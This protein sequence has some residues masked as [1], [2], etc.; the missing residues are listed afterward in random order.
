MYFDFGKNLRDLRCSRGLTQEQAAELL[1][2]SKQSV[3]R[4]ENNVTYPDITFL[5][6]LASFYGVTVDALLG[7]DRALLDSALE[8]YRT[9]HREAH[10][11]GDTAGALALS[12]AM[13]A[14]LPNEPEVM[15]DLMVDAYLRAMNQEG[16]GRR[17][18]LELSLSVGE[19]FLCMTEDL[20]E[21][22]RCIRYLALG[23]KALGRPE[24]AREQM[25]KLPSL[26]SGIELCALEVLEG[27][28]R[29]QHIQSTLLDLAD[30]LQK[31]IFE[32]ASE[33]ALTTKERV[34]ILEK[35]P[36]LLE[37]LFEEGDY[38]LL[39]APLS[40][41]CAVLAAQTRDRPEESREYARRALDYADAA[42]RLT[43]GVHTSVLFRGLAWSPMDRTKP[44]RGTQRET[45]E[46]LLAE[47]KAED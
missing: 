28:E 12:Q 23:H 19:R 14:R 43:P 36:R 22:C 18:G 34:R 17:R 47:G 27:K 13:Y 29:Q 44:R 31:L 41:A 3:S 20:E 46:A 35:L 9:R 42:D 16:E 11:R 45:V 5:P 21:K 25:E 24:R 15:S 10:H 7:A 26:W 37:L 39:Y 33:D 40:R 30:I 8:E 2:V 32:R 6:T 4:W 1:D 38:G